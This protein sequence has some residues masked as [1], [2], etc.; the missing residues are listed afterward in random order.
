MKNTGKKRFI[1]VFT[2]AM[3]S[4]ALLAGCSSGDA[5]PAETNSSTQQTQQTQATVSTDGSTSMEKVIG[6]LSEAY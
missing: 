4:A 3:L 5:Q 1:G 2:A 6:Y